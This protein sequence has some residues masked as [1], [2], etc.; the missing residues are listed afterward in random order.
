MCTPRTARRGSPIWTAGTYLSAC[1][2]TPARIGDS[3]CTSR[4]GA[5]ELSWALS[6]L[7]AAPATRLS[8]LLEACDEGVERNGRQCHHADRA[9]RAHLDRDGR[10]RLDVG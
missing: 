5:R 3:R 8:A 6:P 10:D 9:A 7:L 1:R 4:D 2:S